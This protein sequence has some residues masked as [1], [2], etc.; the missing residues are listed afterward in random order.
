MGSP[1]ALITIAGAVA[2]GESADRVQRRAARG[3][4]T[5]LMPGVYVDPRTWD[6]LTDSERL[7]TRMRAAEAALCAPAAGGTY[8]AESA[9]V[10]L[11]IP[12]LGALPNRPHVL[13]SPGGRRNSPIMRRTQR[14]DHAATATRVAGFAVTDPITTAIDLAAWRTPLGG[15]VAISAVLSRCFTASATTLPVGGDLR[16]GFSEAIEARGAFRGVDRVRRALSTA[17]DA[18]ESPLEA[19][20]LA[21]CEDLGYERP[22]QQRRVAAGGRVYRT[23]FSWDD[24]SIVLEADGMVKYRSIVRGAP[25]GDA[26]ALIGE[27]LREDAIRSVVRSFGRVTWRE[28]VDGAPLDRTLRR[29]GVPRV[30]RARPLRR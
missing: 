3:E 4:L 22:E 9:A 8:C 7:L 14:A 28:A 25:H 13:V 1:T 23:D 5:R 11:G 21:R 12:L 6:S 16:V 27:K 18:C 20:V 29:L 10:A 19:I 24:G 15:V 2:A 17:S 26:D 30:R